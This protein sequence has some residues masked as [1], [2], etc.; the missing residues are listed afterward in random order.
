[1]LY[2]SNWNSKFVTS[3]CVWLSV[4]V[5]ESFRRFE[6]VRVCSR[7]SVCVNLWLSVQCAVIKSESN[8]H[9]RPPK[10]GEAMLGLL[11]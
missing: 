9:V 4:G 2:Y 10:V 1:M 5:G 6:S 8:V 7:T 11:Q 3:E